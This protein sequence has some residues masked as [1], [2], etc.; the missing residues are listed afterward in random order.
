MVLLAGLASDELLDDG[1]DLD[2]ARQKGAAVHVVEARRELE[3]A[4]EVLDDFNVGG[5]DELGQELVVGEDE[6]TELV[7]L[8]LVEDVALNRGD[9]GAEHFGSEDVSE[10]VRA[11]LGEPQEQVA[12]GLMLADQ[13]GE[14]LAQEVE[15]AILHKHR[16]ALASELGRHVVDRAD[17]GFMPEVRGGEL[18][19]V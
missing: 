2:D 18:E 15:L 9:H 6:I 5:G 19:G 13:T 17:D 14:C 12:A 7:G 1:E 16:G 3:R 8:L 4:G 10:G 11:L